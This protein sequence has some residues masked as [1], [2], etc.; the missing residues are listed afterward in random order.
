MPVIA[1]RTAG[2]AVLGEGISHAVVV[3]RGDG[4]ALVVGGCE[5]DP[6]A[7]EGP[8]SLVVMNLRDA[9]A[10]PAVAGSQ[11]SGVHGSDN[12]VTAVA[13]LPG[14]EYLVAAVGDS[15]SQVSV[16]S[17]PNMEQHRLLLTSSMPIRA[18]TV[19]EDHLL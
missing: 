3:G 7:G 8:G 9:A 2:T 19:S 5:L 4:A 10:A 16:F 18:M 11:T 15:R 6:Y 14:T 17:L 12:P 1:E 13:A